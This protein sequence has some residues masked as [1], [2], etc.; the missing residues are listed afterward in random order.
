MATLIPNKQL[1]EIQEMTSSEIQRL[2]ACEVYDGG[3]YL[4][5]LIPLA[6][7]DSVVAD[8]IRTKAEYLSVSFNSNCPDYNAQ[9]EKPPLYVSDKPSKP[10]KMRRQRRKKVLAEV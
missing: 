2:K 1:T 9:E 6:R 10:K 4:F 5:T 8:N 7:Y 3:D